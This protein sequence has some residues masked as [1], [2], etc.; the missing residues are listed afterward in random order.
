MKAQTLKAKGK[1]FIDKHGEVW[2]F[3]K[4]A[5]FTGVGASG[6]ELVVHMLLLNYVFVA[7]HGVPVTN[8]ILNYIKVTDIGYM[9]SYLI[10]STLGYSIAFLL[11]RKLTFKADSNPV[12][13]AFFAILLM[14][15]NIFACTWIGSVLSGI[16]VSYQWGSIGDA[17]IKVVSMLVPSIWIY[18]ANRFIIHRKKKKPATV[19]V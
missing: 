6:T 19:T 11:N 12:V 4:W 18:P 16:T 15:F 5:F 13:S 14:I 2:K 8:T 10:S 9:Y 3:I 7:L 1:N 17:A